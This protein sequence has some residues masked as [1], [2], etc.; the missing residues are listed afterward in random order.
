VFFLRFKQAIH[1]VFDYYTNWRFSVE[2]HLGVQQCSLCFSFWFC[3]FNKKP[4]STN[5]RKF[6]LQ[7]DVL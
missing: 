2:C 7:W 6:E 4:N 1:S 3:I 5:Q